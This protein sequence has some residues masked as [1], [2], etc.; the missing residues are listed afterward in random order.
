M[1]KK[2]RS[3][4][5][6]LV[7]CF[8]DKYRLG[9][10]N[11]PTTVCIY[12]RRY[13]NLINVKSKNNLPKTNLIKVFNELMEKERDEYLKN[14]SYQSNLIEVLTVIANIKVTIQ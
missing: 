2:K 9:L 14:N 11:E 10:T 7:H 6:K 5:P 13:S 12:H 8:N 3:F 1:C 4:E